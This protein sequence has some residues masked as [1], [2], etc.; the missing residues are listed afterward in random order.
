M[1]TLDLWLIKSLRFGPR[2]GQSEPRSFCFEMLASSAWWFNML[3]PRQ[4]SRSF[5]ILSYLCGNNLRQHETT[6]FVKPRWGSSHRYA[7]IVTALLLPDLYSPTP[8]SDLC[9][10]GATC[11]GSRGTAI[12]TA[13]R[14][15]AWNWGA[16]GWSDL[17]ILSTSVNWQTWPNNLLQLELC[18]MYSCIYSS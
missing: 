7:V 4:A 13:T 9:F 11:A 5:L 14:H 1:N 16:G 2:Q 17:P 10:A 18:S 6:E 15:L 3:D 12:A 8:V